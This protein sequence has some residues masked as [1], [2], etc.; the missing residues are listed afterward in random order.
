MIQPKLVTLIA[1]AQLKLCNILQGML[2]NLQT[3]TQLTPFSIVLAKIE[4]HKL[5]C[6]L[7]KEYNLALKFKLSYAN[8]IH[9]TPDASCCKELQDLIT[10]L[11]NAAKENSSSKASEKASKGKKVIQKCPTSRVL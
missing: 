4:L 5:E 2:F 11:Q 6:N 3:L 7:N 9:R 10:R 1:S 8:Q